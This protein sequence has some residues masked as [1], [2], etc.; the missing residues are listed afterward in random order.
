MRPAAVL[1]C[2]ALATPGAAARAAE[3]AKATENRVELNKVGVPVV[4]GGRVVNYVFV[5]ARLTVAPGRDGQALREK[6]P[7]LRDA[8]VRAAHRTPFVDPHDLSRV[9]EAALDAALMRDAARIAGPGAFVRAEVV[10]QQ[11]L[12]RAGLPRPAGGGGGRA[13]IP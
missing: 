12:R 13:I 11:P 9:D 10:A 7:H 4:W 5:T 8:L 2:A 6:E 3:P 1:L